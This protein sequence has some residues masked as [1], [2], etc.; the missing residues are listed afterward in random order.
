MKAV[1]L[2]YESGEDRV[3]EVMKPTAKASEVLVKV[4]YS[5]IDTATK[6]VVQKTWTGY[7]VHAQTKPLILGWHYSGTV[8]AVGQGVNNL[9]VGEKVWGFLQYDTKQNQ[10][11]FAEYITVKEDECARVPENVSLEKV[12]AAS[13]EALTALQAL[14][15]KGGLAEKESILV[16]GAGGGVGAAAVQIAKLIGA[17]VTAVCS[18]KDVE[19]VKGF[20]ADVVLDRTQ[21][22]VFSNDAKYDV[23]FDTPAKYSPWRSFKHLKPKGVFVVTLP[24]MGLLVGMLLSFFNGKKASFVECHSTSKDLE[25]VG[26]WLS[27]DG[28]NIDI[29]STYAIKDIGN[30]LKRQGDKAKAGRVVIQ[31][32]D[33]WH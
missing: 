8:E 18:T 20:G 26:G 23:I 6:D 29:D 16:L 19:R 7:F 3:I 15:D 25:L 24:S 31:V 22:A 17:H 9:K 13:T 21:T 32:E 11:A 5:A 30:A 2:Q 27:S 12:T 1:E 14:R 10:G 33:G 28:L 4:K